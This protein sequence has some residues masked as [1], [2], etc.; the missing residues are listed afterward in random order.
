MFEKPS[1]IRMLPFNAPHET[2]ANS[3]ALFTG[4]V[5]AHQI[6]NAEVLA[7]LVALIEKTGLEGGHDRTATFC[8]SLEGRAPHH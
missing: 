6:C 2:V 1:R 3:R 7:A 8:E 5:N 4:Y